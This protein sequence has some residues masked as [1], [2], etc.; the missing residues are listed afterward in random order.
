M[1]MVQHRT[2]PPVGFMSL[3]R[4]VLS[5]CA[6]Y[7][8]TLGFDGDTGTEKVMYTIVRWGAFEGLRE[9]ARPSFRA[10]DYVSWL[11]RGARILPNHQ[12]GSRSFGPR[13][14]PKGTFSAYAYLHVLFAAF[15]R[16]VRQRWGVI[17]RS[18]N[19]T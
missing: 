2:V 3:C 15:H 9:D 19:Q 16:F 17:L 12:L 8:S 7:P 11:L 4:L 18:F 5:Y 6:I 13:H 10:G 14:V 1:Q